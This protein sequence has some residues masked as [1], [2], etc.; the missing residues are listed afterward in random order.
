[1]AP[2]VERTISALRNRER[3]LVYGDYDVDGQA[4][5]ALLVL[6]LRQLGAD[7]EYFMPSRLEDGYGLSLAVVQR[8]AA[9]TDLLITVDCGIT[10]TR[11]VAWAQANGLDC[12]VTDHHEPSSELPSAVACINPKRPDC[13]YPEKGLA[14]CGVAFKFVQALYQ[15][16]G[17]AEH[18]SEAWLDLVA[19]GT[20]A[21]IVP[22]SG[23]NR[24]FVARG[25][26]RFAQRCG[27]QALM[28]VAGV[29]D[30][31]VSAGQVAFSLAPRLNAAGR[32]DD[33][34]LGV[35]LLTT[36]DPEKA[37]E[38][39]SLLDEQNGLRQAV[40]DGVYTEAERWVEAHADLANDRALVVAGSG[41]HPGVIGIVA[42]R[43]V[44]AYSRP[45]I[46]LSVA[47]GEAVGSGRSIGP[48]D[49]HAGLSQVKGLLARFGGHRMAAGLTIDSTRID[50]FREAFLAVARKELEADD[51]V[52][53][54][55][56]DAALPIAQIDLQLA[57]SVASL[58][59]FG[60]GNPEPTFFVRN[61]LVL[62]SQA[63]GQEG[64]H[65]RVQLQGAAGVVDAIGFGLGP[66]FSPTV[67]TGQ[68]ID[69]L[70]TLQANV[71]QGRER[72][73][74]RIKDAR[75]ALGQAVYA[76]ESLLGGLS[77]AGSPSWSIAAAS[78]VW[79]YGEEPTRLHLYDLRAEGEGM[80]SAAIAAATR[81]GGPVWVWDASPIDAGPREPVVVASG[82][83]RVL[84]C[85]G[86]FPN[87]PD[88]R[89]REA[90][91]VF[92][93]LPTSAQGLRAL[94]DAAARTA[95][96]VHVY[97]T[98]SPAQ[99]AEA[100]VRLKQT[101][102]P[103]DRLRRV[104]LALARQCRPRAHFRSLAEL[105]DRLAPDAGEMTP[106]GLTFA[107][108][109]FREIALLAVERLPEGQVEIVVHRIV[110]GRKVDLTQSIRYNEMNRELAD[111]PHFAA[112]LR[113]KSPADLI[114]ALAAD[115][116]PAQE[117]RAAL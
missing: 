44:E 84:Y 52:P 41:W 26:P 54:Y 48:F 24:L 12:I 28:A 35:E 88:H 94:L 97:L 17:R 9:T 87:I 43:L 42:S 77:D 10:A 67:R 112:L 70:C 8:V 60:S 93:S 16:L 91:I 106:A 19:L 73:Q 100:E 92:W 98:F 114:A 64:A 102:L 90:A 50:A 105:A 5:T 51:L 37:S 49:L 23:E 39:A 82:A 15:G 85:P 33:A 25:L 46:V 53:T 69:L 80:Q 47:G 101:A 6:A 62:S 86:R 79:H 117:R 20:V 99:I 116:Q 4:S 108:D 38:L 111:W 110:P 96:H 109:V 58:S 68:R 14:G 21:D 13:S 11:E 2:A 113:S 65:W 30:G 40:E 63:V 31:A 83:S 22:I 95:D 81:F 36:S 27:L 71:W 59:P 1:M 57:R 72:V 115:S 104:F 107:L 32:M 103:I 18:E 89:A 34:S 45:A 75:P 66:A 56:A 3:I 7:V 61:A 55:R 76:V 74:L 78:A 29:R